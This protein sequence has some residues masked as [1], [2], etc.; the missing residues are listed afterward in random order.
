MEDANVAAAMTAPNKVDGARWRGRMRMRDAEAE[1]NLKT[2]KV[3]GVD[4]KRRPKVD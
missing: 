3:S 1:R 4:S 2:Y